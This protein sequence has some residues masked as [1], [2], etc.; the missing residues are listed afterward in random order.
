MWCII[1]I[2]KGSDEMKKYIPRFVLVFM[3]KMRNSTKFRKMGLKTSFPEIVHHN[4]QTEKDVVF[5]DEVGVGENVKIGCNTYFASGRISPGVT[6]GRY[7]SISRN[8]SLGGTEHPINW[9]T[10][11]TISYSKEYFSSFE[12]SLKFN[13]DNSQ[14]TIIGNDVW[15]GANAIISRGVKIGDGAIVGAGAIVT[16]DVPEYAIVVGVP[17][18]VLKYRFDEITIETLKKLQWWNISS[19]KLQNIHWND[20]DLAI[21]E[22]RKILSF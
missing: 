22:I 13:F 6:I 11:S 21:S 12:K 14:K 4:I 8:V 19:D 17:A 3:R 20:I 10:S 15:I 1:Y 9:L 7:C 18:V 16:K 2:R 5:L